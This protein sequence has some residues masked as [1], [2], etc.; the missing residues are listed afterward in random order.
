MEGLG[1][2]RRDGGGRSSPD[3]PPSDLHELAAYTRREREKFEALAESHAQRMRDLM[4]QTVPL[5][6]STSA[7]GSVAASPM[8]MPPPFQTASGG[9]G[10]SAPSLHE[11]LSQVQKHF[12]TRR[13]QQWSQQ[14]C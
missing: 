12:E 7:A 3:S 2:F 14:V 10:A 11:R 6:P 5:S 4:S 9:G 8:F 13:A 1:K